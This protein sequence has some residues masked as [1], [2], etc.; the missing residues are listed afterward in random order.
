MLLPSSSL[1][2][3]GTGRDRRAR[4][5]SARR[6]R[7]QELRAVRKRALDLDLADRLGHAGQRLAPAQ[8]LLA[9][10]HELR[11]A[12]AVADLL[13]HDRRD[14]GHLRERIGARPVRRPRIAGRG[15]VRAIGRRSSGSR[16]RSDAP[17]PVS[18]DG[19]RGLAANPVRSAARGGAAR[20]RSEPSKNARRVPAGVSRR[21][22]ATPGPTQPRDN[23]PN[24]SS[25]RA[26]RSRPRAG[27]I[28]SRARGAAARA[29][30]PGGAANDRSRAA[31][32]ACRG[33]RGGRAAGCGGQRGE[34]PFG[35]D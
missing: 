11:D 32:G 8:E 2:G 23:W 34:A 5:D 29:R 35:R 17:R 15:G 12:H 3:H 21:D 6:A 16:P 33:L 18:A 4:R 31:S 20:S 19:H 28:S 26:A 27:S 10:G 24:V 1:E 13:E 7:R 14:E 22:R 25:S 30:P 9:R